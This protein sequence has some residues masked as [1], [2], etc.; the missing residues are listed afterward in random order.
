MVYFFFLNLGQC[1]EHCHKN[2]ASIANQSRVKKI[3]L[4]AFLVLSK[5]YLAF[6]LIQSD[7]F[8][9]HF[10][11]PIQFLFYTTVNSP[12]PEPPQMVD[13]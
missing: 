10:F 13:I 7:K 9:T 6:F 5:Q 1:L 4:D 2:M 8:I 12:N 11:R 3:I